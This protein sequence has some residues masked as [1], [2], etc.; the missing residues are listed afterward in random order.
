MSNEFSAD[1]FD[2]FIDK[3]NIHDV[4]EDLDEAEARS[5][6]KFIVDENILL[7]IAVTSLKDGCYG[8]LNESTIRESACIGVAAAMASYIAPIGVSDPYKARYDALTAAT[9]IVGQAAEI[10]TAEE[11]GLPINIE[12]WEAEL[13]P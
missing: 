11:N 5:I 4:Q 6:G 3:M 12:E 10:M 7:R 13:E 1:D 2:D 9:R 8:C